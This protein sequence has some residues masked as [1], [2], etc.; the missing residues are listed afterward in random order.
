MTAVPNAPPMARAEKARPVAVERKACGAVNCTHST[1]RVSGPAQPIRAVKMAC[2]VPQSGRINAKQTTAMNVMANVT[3]SGVSIVRSVKEFENIRPYKG[4]R[5]HILKSLSCRPLRDCHR[6]EDRCDL[7]GKLSNRDLPRVVFETKIEYDLWGD[8]I[9]CRVVN[10]SVWCVRYED[11][12]RVLS[13]MNLP[14]DSECECG[15]PEIRACCEEDVS[16]DAVC[17]SF[18]FFDNCQHLSI[19]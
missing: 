14:L 1:S 3:T 6:G 8:G 18:P 17:A 4:E 19:S 5:K 10:P 9:D 16:N 11:E 7:V 12:E 13:M 2:G 15:E